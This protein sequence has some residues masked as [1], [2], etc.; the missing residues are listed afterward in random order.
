MIYLSS[1]S[2]INTYRQFRHDL[3]EELGDMDENNIIA[4]FALFLEKDGVADNTTNLYGAWNNFTTPNS[5]YFGKKFKNDYS[6]RPMGDD[7][8][9]EYGC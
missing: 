8:D 1:H 6:N 5:W 4:L 3:I 2:F 7:E 9:R